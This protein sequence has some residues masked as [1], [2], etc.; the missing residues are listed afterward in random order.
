MAAISL[1][2]SKNNLTACWVKSLVSSASSSSKFKQKSKAWIST[3]KDS[4]N[5]I[6]RA[7]RR[8]STSWRWSGSTGRKLLSIWLMLGWW[9]NWIRL[10]SATLSI[11]SG[12][13]SRE[14]DNYVPKWSTNYQISKAKRS[15]KVV[16][17]TTTNNWWDASIFWI[18]KPLK[19]LKV[20]TSLS[21]CFKSSE[22]TGWS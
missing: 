13:S 5:C 9:F 15:W 7:D 11:L 6:F 21:I 16:S 12:Q 22:R 8:N 20:S 14:K 1:S 10:I 18:T 17:K 2:K 4:S 19:K 3:L